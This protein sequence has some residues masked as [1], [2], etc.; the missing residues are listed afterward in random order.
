[1]NKKFVP[2][3]IILMSSVKWIDNENLGASSRKN[4]SG[5]LISYYRHK[6][7]VFQAKSWELPF[8]KIYLQGNYVQPEFEL[9]L[10]SWNF[11]RNLFLQIDSMM[12]IYKNLFRTFFITLCICTVKFDIKNHYRVKK[13][14][15]IPIY[16]RLL[17][18]TFTLS[19]ILSKKKKLRTLYKFND[20]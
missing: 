6:L 4:F 5:S 9:Y 13:W 3:K 10:R 18:P 1:M 7:V 15:R 16:I 20:F 8:E 17:L 12:Y 11:L 19:I 2:P 14:L